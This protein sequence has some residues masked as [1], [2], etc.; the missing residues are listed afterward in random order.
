[1]KDH[2]NPAARKKEFNLNVHEDF[3]VNIFLGFIISIFAVPLISGALLEKGLLFGPVFD[4]VVL[5]G[6][7]FQI[8]P[9]WFSWVAQ[10]HEYWQRFWIA[11][12]WLT[13]FLELILIT[14]FMILG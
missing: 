9:A 3:I 10:K 6:M 13:I 12:F 11:I 14:L 2:P 7:G 1:M 8:L 5:F 4:H